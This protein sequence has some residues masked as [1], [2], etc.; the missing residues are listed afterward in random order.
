MP[1]EIPAFLQEFMNHRK[2]VTSKDMT[3]PSV[4]KSESLKPVRGNEELEMAIEGIIE[5]KP[6]DKVVK[7]FL[8]VRIDE[9]SKAKMK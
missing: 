2:H 9:L 3:S 7:D 8:K 4:R 1:N 6:S 5:K